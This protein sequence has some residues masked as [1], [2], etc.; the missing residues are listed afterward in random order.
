MEGTFGNDNSDTWISLSA[1]TE[2]ALELH[3][4]QKKQRDPETS[5][6]R[7]KHEDGP[8]Q[9]YRIAEGVRRI[10]NFEARYRR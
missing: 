2:R 5:G 8:D 6:D 4:K 10:K 9:R 1:A 7:A 3:E